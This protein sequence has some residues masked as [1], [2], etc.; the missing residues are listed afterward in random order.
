[1]AV[2]GRGV[3]AKERVTVCVSECDR[4][5]VHD[6]LKDAMAPFSYEA[7]ESSGDVS[8]GEWDYWRIF[9]GGYPF[10][11]MPGHEEDWRIVRGVSDGQS[12]EWT[13]SPSL[14]DGGPRGI[15]DFDTGRTRAESVARRN[16]RTWREFAE[17][18]PRAQGLMHFW[19]LSW[20]RPEAYS[21]DQACKDYE[22]QP[23]VKAIR[24]QSGVSG[25]P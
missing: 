10:M 9:S 24:I 23:L 12:D 5:E 3:V 6:K 1:M 18:Y 7:A 16:W 25:S 15:L 14:C 21:P 13:L 17:Q 19:R 22:E 2:A 8:Q 4:E 11:V 20:Q